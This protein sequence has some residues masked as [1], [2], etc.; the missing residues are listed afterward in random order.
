[1]S[2]RERPQDRTDSPGFER[3]AALL[4]LCSKRAGTTMTD[5]RGIQGPQGAIALRTPL[6]EIK[7]VI[8]RAPQCPIGLRR[9]G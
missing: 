1:M 3:R 4:T 8:G 2:R 6:L 7:R 9:K 5:T